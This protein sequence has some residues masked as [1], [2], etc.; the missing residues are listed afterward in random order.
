M[1]GVNLVAANLGQGSDH[2]QVLLL[3]PYKYKETSPWLLD[4]ATWKWMK[5]EVSDS[6]L[7]FF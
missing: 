7:N 6:I 2:A 4:V 3:K 5:Y 1:T